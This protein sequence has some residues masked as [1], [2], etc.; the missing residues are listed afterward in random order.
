M[1]HW[2]AL[3]SLGVSKDGVNSRQVV[4]NRRQD[5]VNQRQDGVNPYK[6]ISLTYSSVTPSLI[7]TAVE[8][9]VEKLIA[10]LR[11]LLDV[12]RAGEAVRT[13]LD[14]GCSVEELRKRAQ[15]FYDNRLRW[16]TDRRGGAAYRG[17][18][19]AIPDLRVEY[20]WPSA[21]GQR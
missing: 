12:H 20:G 6:D 2:E 5:G 15:W 21:G 8:E 18:A 11:K 1:I 10:N 19:D 17:I 14:N 9:E 3:A 13:A 7:P 4:V 16:A